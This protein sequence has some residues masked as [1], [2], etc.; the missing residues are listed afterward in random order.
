MIRHSD[1]QN[2]VSANYVH[3]ERTTHNGGKYASSSSI[4][5]YA[6]FC[7]KLTIPKDVTLEVSSVLDIEEPYGAYGSK[8]NNFNVD[9]SSFRHT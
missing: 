9:A 6:S 2:I 7:L 8:C 1:N 4:F 5:E 3:D